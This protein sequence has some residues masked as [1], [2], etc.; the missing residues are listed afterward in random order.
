MNE[1]TLT[2][3]GVTVLDRISLKIT[4]GAVT[5]ISG[6]SGSGKTALLKSLAG[7]IRI[8]DGEVLYN[9]SNISRM[10]E[11]DFFQMQSQS[12][13]VFQD[14]A[15]WANRSLYE[16]LAVPLRILKPHLDSSE[17]DMRI[18]TAVGMLG[19]S[20]DLSVRP[21]AISAGEKE[22]F[23][24][25][26][27]LMTDP[28]ILFL[29]EPTAALDKKNISR[30]NTLIGEL[31]KQNKTIIIVTHDF[32]LAESIAD[33]IILIKEGKIA[34]NGR[35]HMIVQSEDREISAII[36]EMKGHF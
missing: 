18:K 31:K 10:D 20:G 11:K 17:I 13:F 16:N 30:V 33:D 21:A 29:D 26:R 6:R 1:A 2:I 34:A 23:S 36:K 19:Y 12:G 35:F 4:P 25:L 8:N 22:I 3:E 5:V 7:L 14:A 15:L 32:F 28:E 24:F 9:G 27:A